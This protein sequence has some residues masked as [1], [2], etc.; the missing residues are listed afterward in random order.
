MFALYQSLRIL[1]GD[2]WSS[3]RMNDDIK[4]TNKTVAILQSNY[5]PWKGY[6]D[7][8]ASVDEFILYDDMQ[9]TKNDW[10]NRNMIKTQLGP[11]WLTI[12]IKT[13]GKSRQRIR[14][15][16]VSNQNWSRLHWKTLNQNYQN[17]ACFDEISKWLEPMYNGNKNTNL[18][19]VNRQFI[20]AICRYLGI[21]TK[22][23]YSWDYALSGGR[24]ER[25]IYLCQQAGGVEY[26][27]GPAAQNHL[28]RQ[29]F[30]SC[31]IKLS[32]FDY[33]HY[34]EYPQLWGGFSH[35]VSILDLLFNCGPE[36]SKY[37]RYVNT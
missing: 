37:M 30:D 36:S 14:D 19:R 13:R 28:D 22:I 26:V 29:L 15:T 6:F 7:L 24:T 33:E 34:S 23:T 2:T 4:T 9:Y 35:G 17:A 3:L 31:Q 25:L 11:Q 8:I 18:S 27:S 32:W 1:G 21:T 12:P 16:E 5:I 20:E 10:R